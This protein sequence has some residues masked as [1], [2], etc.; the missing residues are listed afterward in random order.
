MLEAFLLEY[1]TNEKTQF[2]AKIEDRIIELG[3]NF[4]NSENKYLFILT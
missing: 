2:E 4:D 3:L 1:E